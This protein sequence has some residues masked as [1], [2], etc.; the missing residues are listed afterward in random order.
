MRKKMYSSQDLVKGM[1]S[2]M[3]DIDKILTAAS[4]LKE[5]KKQRRVDNCSREF[6]GRD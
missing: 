2:L 3:D 4:K 1:R 5:I 6:G